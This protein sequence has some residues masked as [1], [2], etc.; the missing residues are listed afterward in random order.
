[1]KEKLIELS[2]QKGFMSMG[3]LIE[4]NDSYFFLWCCELQEWMNEVHGV[5]VQL[6]PVIDMNDCWKFKLIATQHEALEIDNVSE[7][8][9]ELMDD[10]WLKVE[11]FE[12][13]LSE[14]LE[15]VEL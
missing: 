8:C 13:G 12:W 14:A 4:V 6:L 2:R 15:F 7:S 11:A 10:S 5:Y 9:Q 3:N 1:M